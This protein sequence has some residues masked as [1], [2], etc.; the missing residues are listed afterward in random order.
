MKLNL[1]LLAAILLIPVV[2][3]SGCIQ[4]TKITDVSTTT[5]ANA[6]TTSTIPATS[7]TPETV[8]TSEAKVF[9]ITAKQWEFV[10]GTIRVKKGDHVRL[11]IKTADVTHG[12][13]LPEYGISQSINPGKTT[14]IEFTADKVGTFTFYCNVPCGSGHTSMKGMLIVSES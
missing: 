9:D 2:I 13:S 1:I 3:V 7:T 5:I 8:E 6:A 10:P 11:N 4:Q 14:V 12:F